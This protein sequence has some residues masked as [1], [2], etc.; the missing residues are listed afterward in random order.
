MLATPLGI[1]ES[2]VKIMVRAFKGGQTPAR[3][4]DG[5][6]WQGKCCD[7]TG[8]AVMIQP[9]GEVHKGFLEEAAKSRVSDDEENL[10]R[11]GRGAVWKC[12]NGGSGTALSPWTSRSASLSSD[13]TVHTDRNAC[14]ASGGH[15]RSP[16]L[17]TKC[18]PWH[19][20]KIQYTSAVITEKVS[21]FREERRTGPS[22][23]TLR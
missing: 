11:W 12:W 4:T 13:S 23:P 6:G 17:S 15:T 19:V 20:V 10:S 3:E 5:S 14:L 21:S 22:R 7:I 9:G 1:G 2:R 16:L 8:V 18:S